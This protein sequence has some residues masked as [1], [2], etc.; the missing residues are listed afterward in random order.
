MMQHYRICTRCIMDT[1]VADITFDEQGICNYC[2][3]YDERIQSDLYHHAEGQQQLDVLIGRIKKRGKGRPYD[4]V[5]GVSGGADSTY[6]AY[7]VRKQFDLRPLAVHVD[8]GWNAELA[9]DNIERTLRK[10]KIDL[11]TTVLNWEQFRGL[12]VSFLKS[13]IANAE[14]PTD[15]AI[16]AT[17]FHVANSHNIPYIITGSNI[18]TEA[19]M[20][21]SWMADATDWRLIRSIHHQFGQGTLQN[22]PHVS[23]FNLAYFIILKGIK[24]IPILNYVPYVKSD[25]KLLLQ[26][27]LGWRDYGGKHYESIY[28]RFFQ[29]YL[30]PEKFHIDKR[31]AH[32]SNLIL[33]S[34]I[35][36]EEA[37]LSIAEPPCDPEQMEDDIEYVIKKLG[38][39]DDEFSEILSAPIKTVDDYPNDSHWWRRFGEIVRFAKRRAT[40]IG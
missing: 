26:N 20:P 40:N 39:S 23:M 22:Y 3:H 12:Q 14:I 28:T 2:K 10:L 17:L 18:V 25:V 21:S 15:H 5:I 19:I 9:V 6:V 16:V 30:L 1:S 36:R 35:T 32:F 7:I 11:H 24:F 13:S 4:C 31:R 33:S 29:S 34:Q 8:N 27:E 38:I 37:L